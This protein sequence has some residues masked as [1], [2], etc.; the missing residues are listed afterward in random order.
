MKIA[1]L[2]LMLFI[3]VLPLHA[4]DNAEPDTRDINPYTGLQINDPNMFDRRP[5]LVKIVNAP[6]E[7][8][9]LQKGIPQA[10]IVWEYLLAGGITRFAAIFWANEPDDVGPIRSTRLVDFNL[11]RNYRAMLVTSGMAI[12]T[13]DAMY[14]NPDIPQFV[15]SGVGPCPALCRD[16][17]LVNEKQ[18]YRL[19]G[20]LPEVRDLAI[21]LGRNP[22]TEPITGMLFDEAIQN[23]GITVDRFGIAYVN[24]QVEWEWS[25][26]EQAWMRF[27]DGEPHVDV[28]S[29]EQLSAKN[30]MIIEDD[31]VE[32]PYVANDYWGPANFA[33]DVDLLEGGRAVL[34]R[35]RQYIEGTWVR[36]A[37]FDEMQFFDLDGNPMVFTPGNTFFNLVPRWLGGYQLYFDLAEPLQG[38]ITTESVNLRFGPTIDYSSPYPKYRDDAVTIQGR[39]NSG[40]WL[41][42]RD[43]DNILWVSSD[44]VDVDGDIMTLPIVRP[45]NEF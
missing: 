33:F 3:F 34:F 30:V 16:E 2:T 5:L 38:T 17:S 41:Q 25:A 10:D 20:N 45:T 43:E 1:V 40:T 24:T 42:I 31:H 15:V 22:G 27:Q 11:L 26:E 13:R 7:V 14:A 28:P 23:E 19:F 8:R 12:G 35:D 6:A 44:F 4:Q 29:G 37:I 9:P 21:D 36:D 39:N 32:Q 18:E